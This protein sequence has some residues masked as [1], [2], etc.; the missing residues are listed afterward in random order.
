MFGAYHYGALKSYGNMT[1]SLLGKVPLKER[2]EATDKLAMLGLL[3][4]AI[5]PLMDKI[6]KAVTGNKHAHIRRAGSATLPDNI[7]KLEKGQIDFAQVIQ[8]VLTPAVGAKEGLE[9]MF[10]RDLY[11]GEK[12]I[13]RG[14]EGEGLKDLAVESIAPSSAVNK[15]VGGKIS[16]KDYALSMAGVSMSDPNKSKLYNMKDSKSFFLKEFDKMYAQ[17]PKK[18][19]KAAE[20]FNKKQIKDLKEIVK[21]EGL[22]ELPKSVV[23]QFIIT[24]V[25]GP[26]TPKKDAGEMLQKPHYQKRKILN[27]KE[28][29]FSIRNDQ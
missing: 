2:I 24:T 6:L 7:I 16:L 25:G 10:N 12:I 8:S 19:L 18:A 17:D 26:K 29:K 20:S 3:L 28:E 22:K 9:L 13:H 23:N 5:Y 1:K 27:Q 14:M 21:E 15:I 4:F 11:T